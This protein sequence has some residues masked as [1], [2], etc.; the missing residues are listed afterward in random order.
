MAEATILERKLALAKEQERFEIELRKTEKFTLAAKETNDRLNDGKVGYVAEIKPERKA[1][2][3]NKTKKKIAQNH[4]IDQ[5]EDD[6][7][8]PYIR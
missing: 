5:A 6:N 7:I 1:K 3:C 2:S 8:S 4:P